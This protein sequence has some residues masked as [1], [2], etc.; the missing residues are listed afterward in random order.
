[1]V[2][3]LQR[4]QVQKEYSEIVFNLYLHHVGEFQ[5]CQ[6]VSNIFTFF[7]S[8]LWRLGPKINILREPKLLV[9]PTWTNLLTNQIRSLEK[10]VIQLLSL[11]KKHYK[12]YVP[13]IPLELEL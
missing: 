4:D 5:P 2:Q 9:K 13:T 3:T 12:H 11:P 10:T 8:P 6:T 1:M 7:L